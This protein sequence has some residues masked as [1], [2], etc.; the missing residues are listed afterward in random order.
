MIV[1]NHEIGIDDWHPADETPWK[2]AAKNGWRTY[3]KYNQN[4]P[5]DTPVKGYRIMYRKDDTYYS[6]FVAQGISG[7]EEGKHLDE[8][9]QRV[10]EVNVDT[11]N[12]LY[13]FADRNIAENYLVSLIHKE[14]LQIKANRNYRPTGYIEIHEAEG[15]AAGRNSFGDEG[16][17]MKE[18]YIHRE[19]V[20]AVGMHEIISKI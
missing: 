2:E 3:S 6:P 8:K 5:E 15:Y 16:D 14:Y 1:D 18:M 10:G 17:R 11:N 19:P 20:I 9:T 13:F 4:Y 7:I 12:G